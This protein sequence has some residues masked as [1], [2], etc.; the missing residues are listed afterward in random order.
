MTSPAFIVS[1]TAIIISFSHRFTLHSCVSPRSAMLL[2][3]LLSCL[4]T[5]REAPVDTLLVR[6]HHSDALHWPAHMLHAITCW[7]HPS[8]RITAL[9]LDHRNH[10]VLSALSHQGAQITGYHWLTEYLSLRATHHL[11]KS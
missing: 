1:I 7:L 3:V 6:P 5:V 11:V 9:A 4:G 8:S 2:K 10:R